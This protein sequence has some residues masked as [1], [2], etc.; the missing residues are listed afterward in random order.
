MAL[1]PKKVSSPASKACGSSWDDNV[2]ESLCMLVQGQYGSG[3]S[4]LAATLSR[5]FPKEGLTTQKHKGP[6]KHDL[7]DLFWLCFDKGALSGLKERGIAVPRFDVR[8]HMAEKR[9]TV[10]Q[11]VEAGLRAAEQA[12]RGG[13][14]WVIPD[15]L[16]KYDEMLD[17]YWQAAL[18]SDKGATASDNKAIEAVQIP[19]YGRMFACHKLLHDNLMSLSCGVCYLTHSR[20]Q[21]DLGLGQADDREKQRKVRQTLANASG[22]ILVPYITGKGAGVYK[23]DARLQLFVKT[24]PGPGG[25]L[26]RE[27]WAESREGYETKN[28]FELSITGKQEAHLGKLLAKIA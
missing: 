8:T 24:V 4:T 10:M 22:G 11:A 1:P 21:I 5:Y 9:C 7:K 18:L 14:L 19:K 28:S 12:V 23:A 25:K 3:K 26:T 17:A 20:A 2:A 6:P 27:V 16:S 15:T 13:A